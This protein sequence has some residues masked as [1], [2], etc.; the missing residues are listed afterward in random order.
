MSK[1]IDKDRK[2]IRYQKREK[3]EVNNQSKLVKVFQKQ[4]IDETPMEF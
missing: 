4:T 1:N 2:L 3:E